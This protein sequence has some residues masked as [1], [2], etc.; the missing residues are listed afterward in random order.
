[1]FSQC[2][3]AHVSAENDMGALGVCHHKINSKWKNKKS[4][5]HSIPF[6]P[7][8]G[9]ETYSMIQ[10]IKQIMS[11]ACEDEENEQVVFRWRQLH[12]EQSLLD[13]ATLTLNENNNLDENEND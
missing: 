13:S 10:S 9:R 3:W 11:L 4:R 1:M 7:T 6:H 12:L 5:G 8:S 2:M